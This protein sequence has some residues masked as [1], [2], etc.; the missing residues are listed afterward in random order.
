MCF[1][2][3]C[4]PFPKLLSPKHLSIDVPWLKEFWEILLAVI[5]YNTFYNLT[6]GLFPQNTLLLST[7]KNAIIP[8]DFNHQMLNGALEIFNKTFHKCTLGNSMT[9]A[10]NP[11][12][13]PL[14]LRNLSITHPF[15]CT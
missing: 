7:R 2:M 5:D 12:W 10:G 11:S 8:I 9:H 4:S 14:C 15:L 3:H 1:E 13:T 6:K